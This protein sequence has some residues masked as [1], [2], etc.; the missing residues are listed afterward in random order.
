MFVVKYLSCFVCEFVLVIYQGRNQV[1]CSGYKT[2]SLLCVLNWC[3]T[4]AKF[5]AKNNHPLKYCF[6][7]VGWVDWMNKY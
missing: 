2:G 7:R 3:H 5:V 6:N 1:E 4:V